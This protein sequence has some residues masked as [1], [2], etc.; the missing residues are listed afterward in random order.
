MSAEASSTTLDKGGILPAGFPQFVHQADAF[1]HIAPG[2]FLRL[3]D[4]LAERRDLNA[5]LRPTEKHFPAIL[6][7]EGMP[8]LGRQNNAAGPGN[9]STDEFVHM[10]LFIVDYWIRAPN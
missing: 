1:G 9:L 10:Q 7:A 5:V 3:P 8:Q 2:Q 4:R 6:N